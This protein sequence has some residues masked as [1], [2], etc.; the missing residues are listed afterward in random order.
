MQSRIAAQNNDLDSSKIKADLSRPTSA[1]EIVQATLNSYSTKFI[2]I[3]VNNVTAMMTEVTSEDFHLVYQANM[4]ALFS[5][6]DTQAVKS[7]SLLLEVKIFINILAIGSE[8]GFSG[9][10]VYGSSKATLES[11][12]RA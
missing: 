9:Y 10:S 7:I 11:L 12:T 5:L 3:L 6:I 8:A 2:G 1:H 4:K